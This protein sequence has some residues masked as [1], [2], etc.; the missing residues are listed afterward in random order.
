MKGI[1]QASKTGLIT[2]IALAFIAFAIGCGTEHEP[3]GFEN[4]G[5]N[6]PERIAGPEDGH[7]ARESGLQLNEGK[8]WQ[9]D[10]AT[11]GSIRKMQR[12][13]SE[14]AKPP[15]LL[16]QE[17]NGQFNTLLKQCT[18]KGPEHQQLHAYLGPLRK[19]I[20]ALENCT[21]N[22]QDRVQELN[23]YLGSYHEFFK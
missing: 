12:M 10:Q 4:H 16:A 9:A 22:C 15:A 1:K 2:S 19:K 8:R 11:T 3:H 21:E 7:H 20:Q 23:S 18:M 6:H 14:N 13:A 5:E 17:L